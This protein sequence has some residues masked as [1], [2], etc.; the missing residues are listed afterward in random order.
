MK[1]KNER[2][3]LLEIC[4]GMVS[5]CGVVLVWRGVGWRG[6]VTVLWSGGI[7]NEI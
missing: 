1:K 3:T 6:V 2:K 5:P 4:S 7:H